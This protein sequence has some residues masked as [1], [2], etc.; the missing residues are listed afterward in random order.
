MKLV[1]SLSVLLLLAS[2]AS[3]QLATSHAPA[4]VGKQATA[5]APGE[6]VVAPRV[7]DKAVAKVNGVA[8]TDRDLVR[9]EYAIFPYARQHGGMP[10]TMEPQ[11]RQGALDMII[12][13]ELVYQDA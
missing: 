12:F 10:K 5:K 1:L 11:I 3:A 2:T 9:M 7:T 8:L 13:E 6:E 4:A